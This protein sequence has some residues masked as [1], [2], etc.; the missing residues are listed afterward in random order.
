MLQLFKI[1]WA[2]CR[3][4][5][6][7]QDLPKGQYLLISAI[8]AGII[9]DGFATSILIPKLSIVDVVFTVASY[10]LLLLAAIY[11]LLKFIGYSERSIQTLTAIA[12]SGLF[13]SL[14]L[15][16][17]LLMM[18]SAEEPAKSFVFF[19]LLDNIWRIIV[20]A[21]IFRHALS[22]G[23]LMALILSVSYFLF[24]ILVADA[25]LPAYN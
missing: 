10:N 5:A 13:I 6:G 4:K 17:S 11:L 22:V 16:P 7:P 24:G 21:N 8:L 9:V 19:I 2:I 18:N 12:G 23:L 15:L 25:L 3:L 20:N 1:F 14:I